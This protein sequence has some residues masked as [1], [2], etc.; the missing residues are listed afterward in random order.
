MTNKA[1][2]AGK[3][4]HG[5]ISYT[6]YLATQPIKAIAAMVVTVQRTMYVV[7]LMTAR[8]VFR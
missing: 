7:R 3:A 2:N 8:R 6:T 1:A 5:L 4:H